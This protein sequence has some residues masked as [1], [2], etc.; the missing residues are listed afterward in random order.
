MTSILR[1]SNG[2]STKTRLISKCNLNF[3][4][5]NLYKDFLLESGLLRVSRKE[6]GAEIFETTDR[7][8]EFLTDYTE[9]KG[10]LE[11]KERR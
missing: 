5:F 4:Q 9:I 10:I 3:M 8:K 6:D 1:N 11:T 7:G 2:S